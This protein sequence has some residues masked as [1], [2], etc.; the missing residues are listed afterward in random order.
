MRNQTGNLGLN[1]FC[2]AEASTNFAVA[3]IALRQEGLYNQ[4]KI[5]FIISKNFYG[6]HEVELKLQECVDI[7][8]TQI[9]KRSV[10]S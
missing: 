6:S 2:S 1:K 10:C 8:Y 5:E 7:V 9:E 3:A 4:V